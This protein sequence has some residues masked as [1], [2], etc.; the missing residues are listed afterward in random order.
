VI[1][2][3]Y[4]LQKAGLP[5]TD[6]PYV[7]VDSTPSPSFLCR[8]SAITLLLR[9]VSKVCCQLLITCWLNNADSTIF[10]PKFASRSFSLYV[11]SKTLQTGLMAKNHLA[12]IQDNGIYKWKSWMGQ[13]QHQYYAAVEWEPRLLGSYECSSVTVSCPLDLPAPSFQASH[14]RF[15]LSEKT[16]FA[17]T[18]SCMELKSTKTCINEGIA[19]REPRQA[20]EYV[21][22]TNL[23]R[24][25][26]DLICTSLMANTMW[27][28]TI[29]PWKKR[30]AIIWL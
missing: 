26:V 25:S 22:T 10:S 15:F 2:W 23:L 19:N 30:P 4:E 9:L 16:C 7:G 21:P 13:N 28:S 11:P 5:S 3:S 8:N 24:I 18:K 27:G 14:L 1:K 17:S 12:G 20:T 6:N 29:N